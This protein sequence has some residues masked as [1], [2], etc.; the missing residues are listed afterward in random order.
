M[1][2][3]IDIVPQRT[4]YCI[5]HSEKLFSNKWVTGK[6]KRK[7]T[8]QDQIWNAVGKAGTLIFCSWENEGMTFTTRTSWTNDFYLTK[9]T[10]CKGKV[11]TEPSALLVNWSYGLNPSE[12]PLALHP[13]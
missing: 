1:F 3:D 12:L 7:K 10:V 4:K 11:L 5:S 6:K 8:Q 13:R 2:N 9:I